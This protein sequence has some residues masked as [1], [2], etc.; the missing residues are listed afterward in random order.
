M[1]KRDFCRSDSC[2]F[3]GQAE[4]VGYFR[5]VFSGEGVASFLEKAAD[6]G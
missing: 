1:G 5:S 3:F 4:R 6:V 2:Y